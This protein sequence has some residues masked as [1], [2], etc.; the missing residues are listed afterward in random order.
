MNNYLRRLECCPVMSDNDRAAMTKR[1]SLPAD[2]MSWVLGILFVDATINQGTQCI[3]SHCRK[4]AVMYGGNGK[5]NQINWFFC[6]DIRDFFS[7]FQIDKAEK[8]CCRPH[9]LSPL[10]CYLLTPALIKE[11]TY[12]VSLQE[13]SCNL[14]R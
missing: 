4:N 12:F 11:L 9:E 13:E 6:D 3:L 1:T 14:L 2:Q 8:S 5:W 7:I 10:S